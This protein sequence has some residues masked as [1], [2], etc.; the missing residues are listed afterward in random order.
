[1]YSVLYVTLQVVLWI[2]VLSQPSYKVTF[3]S[4]SI[5][6]AVVGLQEMLCAVSVPHQPALFK[7]VLTLSVELVSKET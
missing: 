1:M 6:S 7:S 3:L 4:A 2:K 5:V